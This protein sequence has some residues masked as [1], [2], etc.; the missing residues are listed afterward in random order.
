M[1]AI[2]CLSVAMLIYFSP[3]VS[4]RLQALSCLLLL[5]MA[6]AA[7]DFASADYDRQL[8][9]GYQFTT[10][11]QYYSEPSPA[12]ASTTS[13][14]DTFQAA[15]SAATELR[16]MLAGKRYCFWYDRGDHLGMFFRSVGSLFF[17]WSTEGLLNERFPRLDDQAISLLLPEDGAAPR[18]LLV[19]STNRNESVPDH[20]LLKSTLQW[21]QELRAGPTPFFAHYF[22]VTRPMIAP[23]TTTLRTADRIAAVRPALVSHHYFD[24]T[25]LRAGGRW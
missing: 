21:T 4:Q 6:I 8:R 3:A 18:D 11:V 20:P 17:A 25:A 16:P 14:A 5:A 7:V 19:L 12:I 24:N 9:N 2:A 13:R 23:T 22:V 10:M 15:V 1:L